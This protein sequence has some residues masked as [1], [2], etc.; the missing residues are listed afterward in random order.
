MTKQEKFP[1][2]LLIHGT[3]VNLNNVNAID[4]F[5]FGINKIVIRFKGERLGFEIPGVTGEEW[6]EVKKSI[7]L[8]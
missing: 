2:L 3:V 7:G 4:Y 6:V 1:N 5:P 8:A